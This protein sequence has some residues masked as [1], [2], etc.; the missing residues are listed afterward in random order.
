MRIW[1]YTEIVE[2]YVVVGNGWPENVKIMIARRSLAAVY[3][4]VQLIA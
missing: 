4:T 3:I 1:K 2:D